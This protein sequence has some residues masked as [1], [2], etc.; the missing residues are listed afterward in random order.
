VIDLSEVAE[1]PK[2]KADDYRESGWSATKSRQQMS[3]FRL[4]W[5][6]LEPII[7]PSRQNDSCREIRFVRS[8][9]SG[10]SYS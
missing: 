7:F 4:C 9:S 5:M 10:I 6:M 2:L 8:M 1:L 3:E